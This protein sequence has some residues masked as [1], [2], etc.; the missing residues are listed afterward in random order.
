M[1][2]CVM[3]PSRNRLHGIFT[4]FKVRVEL[5]TGKKIKAIRCDNISEYKSLATRYGRDHGINFEFTTPY[6]PEQNGV[7]E[8][9][10]RSLIT[11]ARTMLSD[12][13]LPAKFWAEA[14]LTACYLRNRTPIGPNGMT[15][16]EAYTGTKPS[17]EHLRAW[18][19]VAYTHLASRNRDK[20]DKMHPVGK[21]TCLVGYMP[22]TRHYR[23]YDPDTDRILISTAPRFIEQKRLHINWD[24]PGKSPNNT[25]EA[26]D[27]TDISLDDEVLH[28]EEID[29][30]HVVTRHNTPGSDVGGFSH[31]TDSDDDDPNQQLQQES[32]HI[33]DQIQ[34]DK[35]ADTT[36]HDTEG[37]LARK[38]TARVL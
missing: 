3:T 28:Q 22:T 11:A 4:E 26:L 10:N 13:K 29:T 38:R 35:H 37:T 19:C 12:A 32:S 33:P 23:L 24:K 8:R 25:D 20:G 31:T 1:S 18:G 15:P 9:L 21:R 2:W 16:V 34:E 5:E 7:A 36:G 27:T 30:R 17:V 14:V 6:T